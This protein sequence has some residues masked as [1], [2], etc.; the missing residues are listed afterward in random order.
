MSN[1]RN[2]EGKTMFEKVSTSPDAQAREQE[3]IQFWNKNHIFQR[4][5]DQREGSDVFTFY[6]GR[7]RRTASRISAISKRARS[8]I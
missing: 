6:D 5:I 1:K 2:R 7:R 8:R 4:S 3:V